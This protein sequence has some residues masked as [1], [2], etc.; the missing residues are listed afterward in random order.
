MGSY[1]APFALHWLLV[2]FA[3]VHHVVILV[4]GPQ[5]VMLPDR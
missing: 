4:G 3:R 1:N 5:N 2:R